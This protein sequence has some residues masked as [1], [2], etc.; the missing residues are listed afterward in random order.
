MIHVHARN[1]RYRARAAGWVVIH[2]HQGDVLRNVGARDATGLQEPTRPAVPVHRTP[3][4]CLVNR[5]HRDLHHLRT[6]QAAKLSV[7]PFGGYRIE[8][9]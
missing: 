7:K 1:R 3:S 6:G 2:A 8:V 4:Q 5:A 9:P